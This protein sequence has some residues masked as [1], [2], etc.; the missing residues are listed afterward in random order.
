MSHDQL[1]GGAAA[2][3]LASALAVAL[4]VACE[5]PDT[6][7]ITGIEVGAQAAKACTRGSCG[8]E[9]HSAAVTL[10]DRSGDDW[11]SD[12]A[13]PYSDSDRNLWVW[14]GDR[15]GDEPDY[16]WFAGSD[17]R[18]RT[19]LDIPGVFSGPCGSFKSSVFAPSAT[20][21]MYGTE[22]GWEGLS[23]RHWLE[24][25]HSVTFLPRTRVDVYECT[26]VSHAAA[27][28]WL[29]VADDCTAVVSEVLD[30]GGKTRPV[31]GAVVSYAMT[32][33]EG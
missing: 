22:P 13:G 8:E 30:R 5:A 15:I 19:H 24:C 6:G 16:L 33:E 17:K 29:A 7:W 26:V 32:V 1:P 28:R 31:G 25:S 4:S 14:V 18:R 27:G 21:D 12:G 11:T 2:C 23:A 3:F 10:A 9:R 20:P